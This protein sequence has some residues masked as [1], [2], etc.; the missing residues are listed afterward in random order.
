MQM[1][2]VLN[3]FTGTACDA[4]GVNS[5]LPPNV[6]SRHAAPCMTGKTGGQHRLKGRIALLKQ[7]WKAGEIGTTD[8][9][10]QLQQ[11]LDTQVSAAA[12]RAAVWDAWIRWLSASGQI[13]YWLGIQT[14]SAS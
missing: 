6:F 10:V 4:R 11:T 13:E 2:C 3:R 9:L 14:D 1:R 5:R 7:L 12:L 8:Y